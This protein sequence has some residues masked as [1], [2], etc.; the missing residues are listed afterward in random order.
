M[1]DSDLRLAFIGCGGIALRHVVAMKD[2]VSRN[3]GGFVVTAVCDNVSENAEKLADAIETDLGNRPVIYND[4]ETMLNTEDLDGVDICLPHGLH[5]SVSIACME[6]G[7]HVLCEK[8]IGVS[9]RAGKLMAEAAERTGQILSIAVPHRRQPGQRTAKWVLQESGL[10]GAP[11]TFFHSYTRPPAPPNPNQVM[12]PRVVWRRDRMMSGGGMTLDSGFHYCDSIRYLYG[13]VEK[14]YAEMRELKSGTPV[15]VLERPEDSIYVTFTF[16]SGVVGSWTWSVAAPGEP[17]ARVMFY[18]SEGSLEDTT[19]SRFKIFH[20]FERRPEQRET[21]QLVTADGTRYQMAQLE[22]MYRDTLSEEEEEFLFPGG[23]TD[24]FAIEIREFV[25]LINGERSKPEVGATEG[26][27]S[28]ALGD[29]IY[30]SAFTGDVVR[31]EDV[32]SGKRGSFQK[33]IDEHWGL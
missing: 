19:D 16:A 7:V 30:E 4:F 5:H 10:M 26:I 25:D 24:G 21:G 9:V 1:S 29:A 6:A 27:R 17:T 13:D 2:L 18:G 12:P 8:P 20:L 11:L 15:S 14:V 31:V 23:V 33:S 22:E 3:R 32:F 28:L